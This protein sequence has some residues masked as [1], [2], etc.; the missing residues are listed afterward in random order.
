MNKKLTITGVYS[1]MH[2]LVDMSCAVLFTGVLTNS[3]YA[4]GYGAF[5]VLAYDFFA[6]VLQFPFGMI[7]DRLNRNALVSAL[8]CVLVGAAFA[9]RMCAFP[10]CIVAGIGNALFHVG[11]GVDVLN[12]SEGK[13]SLSGVYVS[14]GA[15]GLYLGIQWYHKAYLIPCLAGAL[16]AGTVLLV[17][18][19]RKIRRDYQVKNAACERIFELPELTSEQHLI[20][21]CLLLTVCVRSCLG[22]V[23]GFTWKSGFY[24][25]LAAVAAVVLGKACGGIIGDRLGWKKTSVTSLVIAAVLFYPAFD[26]MICG[27]FA[28][29]FFNMTM[30]ITLTAMANLFPKRMGAA[31]GVTSAALF[32]GA[33]PVF[34]GYGGMIF[35]RPV[36][37]GTTLASAA[38]LFCG[39]WYYGKIKAITEE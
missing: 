8:G 2:A 19:F 30:P 14:T 37:I 31:F 9:F 35:Q 28:L 10:A 33:V 32:V 7:A 1:L 34:L 39:L 12:V 18:L 17:W 23:M 22:M 21:V 6:F 11:G 38:V 20:V 29:F 16:A 4:A 36:L 13:A 25:G 5:A 26:N 3:G 15:M 27:L 24:T